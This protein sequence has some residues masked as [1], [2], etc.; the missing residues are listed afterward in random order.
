MRGQSGAGRCQQ[1]V[2]VHNL[3]PSFLLPPS[4]PRSSG[5]ELPTISVTYR[6]PPSSADS[7][8][9]PVVGSKEK[10]RLL[11][12]SMQTLRNKFRTFS[13]KSRSRVN[14][15]CSPQQL[16]YSPR[17][18]SMKAYMDEGGGVEGEEEEEEGKEGGKRSNASSRKPSTDSESI[19]EAAPH[20]AGYSSAR[21][22]SGRSDSFGRGVRPFYHRHGPGLKRS[23]SNDTL[24]SQSTLV[25]RP[26][27]LE[28]EDHPLG[29]ADLIHDSHRPTLTQSR[30]WAHENSASRH[31]QQAYHHYNQEGQKSRKDGRAEG[32]EEEGEE[33]EGEGEAKDED[34]KTIEGR[35]GRSVCCCY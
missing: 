26:S 25:P 4:S 27:F 6:Q 24:S 9:Q 10:E 12:S 17:R 14:N 32:R 1:W 13:Q 15:S 33:G 5:P 31:R 2:D 3:V 18:A 21:Y 7:L 34:G 20:S 30:V 16:S 19:P 11:S 29:I 28:S 23:E 35:S 8:P 22:S